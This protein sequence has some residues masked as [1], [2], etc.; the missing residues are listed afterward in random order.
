MRVLIGEPEFEVRDLLVRA[1]K[2]VGHDVVLAHDVEPGDDFDVAIVEPADPALLETARRLRRDHPDVP[3]IFVSVKPPD[4][5]TTALLP[6]V[7]L[8]KP[9]TREDISR[10]LAPLAG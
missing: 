3:L 6:A 1:V 4:A 5:N 10:A 9:F 2:K 7:H 8:V